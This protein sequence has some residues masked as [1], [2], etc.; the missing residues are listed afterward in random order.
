MGIGELRH[1]RGGLD[2]MFYGI[3]V[4]FSIPTVIYRRPRAAETEFNLM[5]HWELAS[6]PGAVVDAFAR[7][8][9]LRQDQIKWRAD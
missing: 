6:E 1:G 5:A 9:G 2:D 7:H 4:G 8:F 3:V